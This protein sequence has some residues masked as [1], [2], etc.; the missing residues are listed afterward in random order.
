MRKLNLRLGAFFALQLLLSP[1]FGQSEAEHRLEI[2]E[3]IHASNGYFN[4]CVNV[5]GDQEDLEWEGFEKCFKKG[6]EVVN[7]ALILNRGDEFLKIDFGFDPLD[8][9][10]LGDEAMENL[11]YLQSWRHLYDVMPSF[12][13][14]VLHIE[15]IGNGPSVAKVLLSKEMINSGK[16]RLV[17]DENSQRILSHLKAVYPLRM[18]YTLEWEELDGWLITKVAFAQESKVP[19]HQLVRIQDADQKDA[20]GWDFDSW[21]WNKANSGVF[22]A[23]ELEDGLYHIISESPVVSLAY[24]D[25]SF[26]G[27]KNCLYHDSYS[28]NQWLSSWATDWKALQNTVQFAPAINR[29]EASLSTTI[30]KIGSKSN[31]QGICRSHVEEVGQIALWRTRDKRPDLNHGWRFELNGGKSSSIWALDS[32]TFEQGDIDP[33]GDPYQRITNLSAIRQEIDNRWAEFGVGYEYSSRVRNTPFW[34][35]GRV[36]FNFGVLASSTSTIDFES[37]ILGRYEQYGGVEL[38]EGVYDFG[39][40]ELE[41]EA[42]LSPSLT[43]A[44]DFSW[45]GRF[46]PDAVNG[47][48]LFA[49][50]GVRIRG[51]NPNEN[52]LSAGEAPDLLSTSNANLH[53]LPVVAVGF[54]KLLIP[55]FDSNCE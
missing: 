33:D 24:D 42:V 3:L 16:L 12:E 6:A 55:S 39:F 14:S 28:L 22:T 32:H 50:V 27:Q 11:D 52:A 48:A 43:W 18:V 21:L 8:R 5:N 26:K 37:Q 38:E 36:A 13:I 31:G 1:L 7:D 19:K 35:G 47:G 20:K 2:M 15:L 54:S 40:Y 51:E 34:S 29:I 44:S 9:F 4:T 41:E 25:P 30:F 46:V 45:V 17:D 10:E 23:V 53:V 49:S